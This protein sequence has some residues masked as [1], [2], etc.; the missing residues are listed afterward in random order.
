LVFFTFLELEQ[1]EFKKKEISIM[2]AKNDFLLLKVIAVFIFPKRVYSYGSYCPCLSQIL[3][4]CYSYCLRM[5]QKP[6][7]NSKEKPL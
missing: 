1:P 5:I 4:D 2:E 7:L 3:P 6:L